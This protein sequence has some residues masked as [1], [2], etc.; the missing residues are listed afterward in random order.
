MGVYWNLKWCRN[1]WKYTT[2]PYTIIEWTQTLIVRINQISAHIHMS[3][4][5]GAA[6][7]I[8][9]CQVVFDDFIKYLEYYHIEDGKH[10]VSSRYEVVID[11][12]LELDKIY[13][14]R[15]CEERITNDKLAGVITITNV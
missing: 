6:N 7:K 3:T 13:I 12:T 14:I 15:D 2:E 8:V 11:N 9:V 5:I 1:G 10:M 4:L